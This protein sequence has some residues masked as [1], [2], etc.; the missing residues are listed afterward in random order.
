MDAGM[1]HFHTV[2]HESRRSLRPFRAS[3]RRKRQ[4]SRLQSPHMLVV[5]TDLQRVDRSGS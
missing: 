3:A 1:S 5:A 2:N 4:N